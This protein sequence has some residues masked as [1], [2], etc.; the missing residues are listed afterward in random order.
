MLI[1]GVAGAALVGGCSST[2]RGPDLGG[3]YD[4]SAR[5]HGP[6]RNPVV[7]IPGILG[8]KLV[9]GDS[10]RVVWGAFA[11]TYANPQTPD[12]ARLLALPMRAGAALDEL[13]DDVRSDGA[14]DRIRIDLFGLPIELNAY[15]HI[16]ATLGIGG[17]RDQGLGEAGAVDYGDDHYTCFQFDYDWRRDVVENARRL[18]DFLADRRAYV[19][20]QIE[21]RF[22]VRD[23]QVK[24]DLVAHS[25]GGLIARYYLRYGAADLPADGSLPPVSWSGAGSVER[26]ILVGTPNAGSVKALSE[27][28]GGIRFSPLLP[29]YPPAV[30][31]TRPAVYQLLP[32]PRH[33]AVVDANDPAEPL[34]V[35]DAGLWERMGWGLAD[36]DQARVLEMLLPEV[37]DASSRRRIALD[38][39]RRCLERARRLAAALDVPAGPPD[40]LSLYLVAGDA[41]ATDAVVA[42]DD[43]GG[44]VSVVERRPGDGTVLRSSAL[45]DERVGR[46]WS[47]L[48]VSPIDWRGVFF[49]FAD[50]LGMTRDPAF[51]DNVLYLLLEDPR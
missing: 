30:R 41:I 49:V 42:V 19:Q 34:D 14:L 40:G 18:D 8:S 29:S 31:G 12:G 39:Q 46:T 21:R 10:G 20:Q 47:P 1:A 44:G 23:P 6:Q 28:V 7:V 33:G 36:P 4:R 51:S 15:V 11:G 50:H 43:S 24:F 48:L 37:G 3:L 9:D 26:A 38:H 22:G 32:R 2:L 45:M 27:L 13:R 5:H 17:Y 25:M 16:L 35:F